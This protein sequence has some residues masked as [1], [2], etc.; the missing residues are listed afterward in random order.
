MKRMF[1]FISKLLFAIAVPCQAVTLEEAVSTTLATHPDISAAT[2][3][4]NAAS[5]NLRSAQGGYLPSLTASASSG[6]QHQDNATT[7]NIDDKGIALNPQSATV[8][9]SQNLFNGFETVH[10]VGYQ[11]AVVASDTFSALSKQ[12]H[13]ALAMIKAYLDVLKSQ[14]LVTLAQSNLQN[15]ER[16][17]DQ[18]RLRTAQGFSRMGDQMQAEARLSQ[19]RNN[20]LTAETNLEDAQS[21]YTSLNGRMPENLQMPEHIDTRLPASLAEAQDVMQSNNPLLKSATADIDAASED[22]KASQAAFYPHVDVEVGHTVAQNQDITRSHSTEWQAMVRVNYN[23][24]QGGSDKATMKARAWQQKEAQDIRASTLRQMT[25]ELNLA[26]SAWQNARKQLPNAEEY[27]QTSMKVRFAYQ[28]QFSLGDR[29]LLDLLDSENEVLSAQDRAVE[30]RFLS[31]YSAWRVS[32]ATGQL[33]DLLSL[34]RTTETNEQDSL[35]EL[36]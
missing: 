30:M 12:D 4:Q 27:A 5:E 31:L 35:P 1:C 2:H 26:W 32:A 20:L 10:K 18:I 36:K 11:K 19:A 24:Y 21:A 29:S 3:R 17:F 23:L 28:N 22:Y 25:E 33:R 8:A 7:R 34:N 13:V 15:H 9:L 16:I 6:R 14:Q